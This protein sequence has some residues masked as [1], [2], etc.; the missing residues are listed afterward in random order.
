MDEVVP[1]E[2]DKENR[3]YTETYSLEAFTKASDSP[4]QQERKKWLMR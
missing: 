1:K 2:R 4:A 3:K